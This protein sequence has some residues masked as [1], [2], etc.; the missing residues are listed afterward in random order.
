M[1]ENNP[2]IIV[3]PNSIQKRLQQAKAGPV[4]ETSYSGSDIIAYINI[5]ILSDPGQVSGNIKSARILAELQTISISST[6]SISPIRVLGRSNPIGYA[7][8]GRTFAGTLVFAAFGKD[9]FSDLYRPDVIENFADSSTSLF[10]DQL[11]PF[12]IIITASNE[13]GGLAQQLISGITLINYGVTY[14]IDDIYTETTYSYVATDVTPLL[15]IQIMRGEAPAQGYKTPMDIR[16]SE[17]SNKEADIKYRIKIDST[18]NSVRR[19]KILFNNFDDLMLESKFGLAKDNYYWE[20]SRNN[21]YFI[22]PNKSN[23]LDVLRR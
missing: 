22:S 2:A 7:R 1:A 9:V 6:R 18:S 21:S 15:P 19:S 12:N 20:K 17:L 8:G 14:S 23:I 3:S 10:V 4:K 11:P 5:P 16:S 13:L